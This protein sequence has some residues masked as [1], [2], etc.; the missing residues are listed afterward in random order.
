MHE[1]ITKATEN[2]IEIVLGGNSTTLY[3]TETHLTDAQAAL[4]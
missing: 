4:G 2:K 3:F 1:L